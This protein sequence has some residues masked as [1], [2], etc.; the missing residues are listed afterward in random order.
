MGKSALLKGLLSTRMIAQINR[1][2]N[3]RCAKA[4]DRTII[5]ATIVV[6]LASFERRSADHSELPRVLSDPVGVEA[7]VVEIAV[8]SRDGINPK[9]RTGRNVADDAASP[10]GN[11]HLGGAGI[12]AERVAWWELIGLQCTNWRCHQCG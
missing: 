5:V 1:H 11:A 9:S 8:E 7:W 2:R 12:Q 10:V 4:G 6:V 3:D